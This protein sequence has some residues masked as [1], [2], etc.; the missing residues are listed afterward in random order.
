MCRRLVHRGPDDI[1]Y[2]IDEEIS[3]AMRRL[4]IID[5]DSGSQPIA[6][7]DE[8][9]WVVFNGEIYNFEEVREALI[10]RGCQFKT[11]SDTEVI[12]QAYVEYGDAF[13]TR[14]RGMW[15]IA[16][17]DSNRHRLLL[18]RD[19][20]GEKPLFYSRLTDNNL[21]FGS[22]IKSIIPA[23]GPL[24]VD[25]AS[26]TEYLAAGY[27]FAPS[28]FYKNIRKLEPG[29]YLVWQRGELDIRRYWKV[30]CSHSYTDSYEEA[31]HALNDLTDESIR[32]CLKSDVEVGAFL[33]G[34][35]DSSII[36]GVMSKYGTGIKSY[37]VGYSGAAAGYNEFAPARAVADLFG[38][39][40]REI[41][42]EA[43]ST[44]DLLPRIIWQYDE[45]HGEPSSVM[46][47]LMCEQV[48]KDI[49]VAL[50]GTG[51]DELFFGYPKH[52]ALAMNRMYNLLPRFVRKN[53]IEWA[54]AS[55]P[56]STSGS[57]IAKRVKRFVEGSSSDLGSSYLNWTNLLSRNVRE[58]LF[59]SDLV[60][61]SANAFGERN[62]RHYL[63]DASGSNTFSRVN[64]LELE[65]Y[66]PE[67]QLAYMD[68]MS[69]AH[70]LEVRSPLCDF[71]MAEFAVSLPPSYRV[72]RS[73]GK[74]ILRDLAAQSLPERIVKRPK[75]GFDSPIGQW[76]KDDLREFLLSFLSLR[77]VAESGLLQPQTVQ[78]IV[79]EHLSGRRDYSMA[80]WSILALEMWHR[81]YIESGCSDEAMEVRSIRGVV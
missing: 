29:H 44:V 51:G 59:T 5:L 68:R 9:V 61:R 25:Y 35:I 41:V 81:V 38:T 69:M 4:A 50:C 67:Y 26:V 12:V 46:V 57:H 18:A 60:E 15:G 74:R 72:N 58:R 43:R 27:V 75:V 78:D 70:S 63:C 66:L 13:L 17:W 40:H 6:N 42:L 48:A 54:L 76:F 1:G 30:D 62:L 24:R 39:D 77:A 33:S 14:L 73:I 19:R 65:G 49:K 21:V 71:R 64:E 37:S 11:K 3:L 45:P 36:T 80:L 34:G 16:I 2:Y 22:E 53:V 47:Y 52:R 10:K 32:Y 56:E 7:E 31:L 55:L 28:T 20:I 79:H 8:S 23:V